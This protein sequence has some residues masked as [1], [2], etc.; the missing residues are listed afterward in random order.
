MIT[1]L[2]VLSLCMLPLSAVELSE[3]ANEAK[4]E[5]EATVNEIVAELQDDIDDARADLV[6]ALE[7]EL[8][9]ATK[10]G[11]LA[12]A[13][14]VQAKIEEY[15]KEEKSADLFG[16]E[17]AGPQ[18]EH[19]NKEGETTAS[20][21]KEKQG[22]ATYTIEKATIRIHAT[23]ENKDVTALVQELVKQGKTSVHPDDDLSKATGVD[24]RAALML[25][26][27]TA[28]GSIKHWRTSWFIPISF[29]TGER[30]T[31]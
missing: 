31:K 9:S 27:K 29:E 24:G 6:K 8:K 21:T 13:Q 19:G 26:V 16:G 25:K 14:A 22:A 28:D 10:K 12:A 2:L 3:D 1:R 11:D 7:K 4:S 15:K 5:Y 18:K 23:G 17:D 30:V 20:E